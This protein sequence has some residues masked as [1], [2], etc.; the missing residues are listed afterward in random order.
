M[1]VYL[2]DRNER[3]DD[4]R[5]EELDQRGRALADRVAGELAPGRTVVYGGLA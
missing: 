3:A 2:K 4:V 1:E 5:R